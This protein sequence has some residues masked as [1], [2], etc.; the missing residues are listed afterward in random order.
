MTGTTADWKAG[1]TGKMERAGS[2]N[3]REAGTTGKLERPEGWNDLKAGTTGK[4]ERP[5]SWNDQKAGKTRTT[6]IA[7]IFAA[8]IY[9]WNLANCTKWQRK[10]NMQP[11]KLDFANFF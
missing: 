9:W 1:T 6:G 10:D 7:G 5:G 2:W 4:L 11:Q 3:K 8:L